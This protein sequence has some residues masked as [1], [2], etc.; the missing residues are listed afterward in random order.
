M[1]VGGE[2]TI[3]TVQSDSRVSSIYLRASKNQNMGMGSGILVHPFF[4]LAVEKGS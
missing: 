2:K 1:L 4:L 3:R